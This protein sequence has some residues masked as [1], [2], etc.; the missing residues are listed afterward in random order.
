MAPV[1]PMTVRSPGGGTLRGGL[2][3][4]IY[5]DRVEAKELKS[6]YQTG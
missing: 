4:H 1:V 2:Q 3:A 6:S 5:L